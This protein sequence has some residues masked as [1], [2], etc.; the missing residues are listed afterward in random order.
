MLKF[1]EKLQGLVIALKTSCN[2]VL[3]V[4]M[5][6]ETYLPALVTNCCKPEITMLRLISYIKLLSLEV[7]HTYNKNNSI[8]GKLAQ[9]HVN[10]EE[11][12]KLIL[13]TLV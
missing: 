1:K 11:R 4:S 5:I 13:M 10:K 3:G 2:Y 9:A 8:V 7:V 12:H 6:V